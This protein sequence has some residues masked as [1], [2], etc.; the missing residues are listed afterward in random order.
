MTRRRRAGRAGHGRV[1]RSDG[2]P[3]PDLAVTAR[4]EHPF[5]AAQDREARLA[6]DGL[7]YEGVASLSGRAAG[8]LVIEANRGSERV[9]RSENKIVVADTDANPRAM[10]TDPLDL[11]LF[12][13]RPVDGVAA[14]DLVVEGV[15]CGACIATI[16]KGLRKQAGVR[17]ARVNLASKRVTVEWNEGALEPPTILERLEALGYPAHPFATRTADG[18]EKARR[19]ALLRCLG[20]AAFGAMNVMLLSVSLWAG[21]DSDPNSA[22][23]DLFHWLSALVALP[24]AAYAAHAV[25]RKRGEGAA[26]PLDSTWTCRSRSASCL[27]SASRSSRRSPTSARLFRQRDDAADVPARRTLSRPAHATAHARLRRQPVGDP[28]PIARS[29]CSRAAKRAKRRSRRS[30]PAIWCSSAPASGSPSTERSK[31][32]VRK[33]IRA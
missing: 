21:A 12:V 28:R 16:E 24:C 27:R 5:D 33:L 13:R 18:V 26:R 11:S 8:L 1:P 15:H 31:T 25:L 29:S 10:M 20:V 23:R 6:S 30:V 2:A 17:G 3:I 14:M 19:E 32:G 4:F 7:D 22:T 9:F